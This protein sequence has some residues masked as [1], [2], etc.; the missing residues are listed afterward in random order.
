MKRRRFF[1]RPSAWSQ[2]GMASA[3]VGSVPRLGAPD[4]DLSAFDSSL[5]LNRAF[6]AV[7]IILSVVMNAL[8][9]RHCSEISYLWGTTISILLMQL[10]T[11]ES[12]EGIADRRRARSFFGWLWAIA[13]LPWIPLALATRLGY[14]K[15]T[16]PTIFYGVG[17]MMWVIFSFYQRL[18]G[19]PNKP[20]AMS[21]AIA[22]AAFSLHAPY[23]AL[24]QPAEGSLV[25]MAVLVGELFGFVWVSQHRHTQ[26]EVEKQALHVINHAAKRVMS[27]TAQ[28]C[29][30]LLAKLEELDVADDE[31]RAKARAEAE[32]LVRGVRAGAITGFHTCKST[33]LQRSLQRRVSQGWAY[34]A[35]TLDT[36]AAASLL[37][38]IGVRDDKQFKLSVLPDCPPPIHADK[39]LLE[40]ILF[41]AAQN[42]R[43]HGEANA[44]IQVRCFVEQP[45]IS[46]HGPKVMGKGGVSDA[47]GSFGNNPHLGQ[48]R[49]EIENRAGANHAQLLALRDHGLDDLFEADRVRDLRACGIGTVES[50]FLGLND[51]QLAAG[52]LNPPAHMTLRVLPAHVRFQLT[53]RVEIDTP[54]ESFTSVSTSTTAD[55]SF[56]DQSSFSL[57]QSF[58]L[59]RGSPSKG[60]PFLSASHGTGSPHLGP[61]KG[62]LPRAVVLDAT[63]QTPSTPVALPEG[64]VFVVADDDE[65]ARIV[66]MQIL[67]SC[68]ADKEHSIIVGASHEEVLS[69]PVA[70]EALGKRFGRNRVVCIFDQNMCYPEGVSVALLWPS[71]SLPPISPLTPTH[72]STLQDLFGTELCKKLREELNWEGVLVIQSANDGASDVT[73]YLAAGADACLG[74]GVGA[75]STVVVRT[76]ARAYDQRHGERAQARMA[77][78]QWARSERIQ[79]D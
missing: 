14:I 38:D 17:S 9:A 37:A 76:L 64:L 31:Q 30:L 10:W 46:N 58:S 53:C 3:L 5:V 78:E 75:I 51:M 65:I 12:V 45:D 41:N 44:S 54:E 63:P 1:L 52:A 66:A 7:Q 43:V 34:S 26:M 77:G 28:A 15:I 6:I 49:V 71:L 20:R 61:S 8:T 60:S 62:A 47:G 42:A 48:L 50:T 67:D 2:P 56:K 33:S 69:L 23:S 19:V 21:N 29:Q 72:L 32:E 59:E 39:T 22:I 35:E 4:P 25:C 13:M 24:G 57:G 27:N 55:Q 70:I 73:Q 16:T 36:F 68:H 11:R 18:V 40:A 74:K 79:A